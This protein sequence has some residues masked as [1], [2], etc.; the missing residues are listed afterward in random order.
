M[1]IY[2]KITIER[3]DRKIKKD[4][5]ALLNS[6]AGLTIYDPELDFLPILYILVPWGVAKELEVSKRSMIKRG[7]KFWVDTASSYTVCLYDPDDN[8]VKCVRNIIL[9]VED[10]LNEILIPYEFLAVTGID[11][12]PSKHSWVCEGKEILSIFRAKSIREIDKRLLKYTRYRRYGVS[13]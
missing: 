7:E 1:V 8:P 9:V 4:Y 11:L 12:R 5:I 10:G 2:A 13:D 6:G 3:E